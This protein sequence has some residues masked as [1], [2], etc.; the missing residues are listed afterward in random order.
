MVLV[1]RLTVGT[2]AGWLP[3]LIEGLEVEDADVPVQSST[4]TLLV[5]GLGIGGTS[6]GRSVVVSTC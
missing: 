6:F 1:S 4:D 3:W 5:E 2:S